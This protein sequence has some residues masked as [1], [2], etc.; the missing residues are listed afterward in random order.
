MVFGLELRSAGKAKQLRAA[1]DMARDRGDWV[2]A[3]DNYQEYLKIDSDDFAIWVQLGHALKEQAK[4]SQAES[5]YERA[6]DINPKDADIHLQ[7]GHLLKIVGRS[8]DAI[9]SYTRSYEIEPTYAAEAEIKALRG[10]SE[11]IFPVGNLRKY[12]SNDVVYIELDDMLI[13]LEAHSTV[14]GIQRVQAEFARYIVES[15][16]EVN[17]S[18]FV[19][20]VNPPYQDCVWRLNP[21]AVLDVVNYATGEKVDH[22]YLRRLVAAARSSA[23]RIEPSKGQCYL[24]LGAFWVFNTVSGRFLHLKRLGLRIGGYIHDLIPINQPEYCD[25]GLCHE[26]LLS[27]GDSMQVFDF[28]LTNSHHTANEVIRYRKKLG[29]TPMPVEAVQLAHANKIANSSRDLW[30]PKIKALKGKKFAMMVSTIE[31]RKN[32]KYLVD[33]WRQ[34]YNEGLEPPDL[35]FV[36]RF[37]WRVN[38][39]MNTLKQSRNFGG[40]LHIMHGLTDG[41]LNKLYK[42]CSFTVFPSYVE[43]WGLPVGEGLAH[44]KP[45]VSSMTSAMPEIGG[46]F[47]DYIDPWNLRD[48]IEVLRKMCFDDQ[49]RESRRLNIEKNFVVR[50]WRDFSSNLVETV[51]RHHKEKIGERVSQANFAPGVIFRPNE[52]SFGQQLPADYAVNPV[53]LLLSS[54]WGAVEHWGAWMLG[55]HGEIEFKSP[56]Q[57][58][59]EIVAYLDLFGAPF[60][61]DDGYLTATVGGANEDVPLDPKQKWTKIPADNSFVIKVEGAVRENGVVNINVYVN[62]EVRLENDL[63][64]A[65]RFSVGIKAIAYALK[66]DAILRTDITEDIIGGISRV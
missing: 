32:H 25:E 56:Y 21:E 54:S 8:D 3:S 57:E 6:R 58:G 64:G 29:L 16:G 9:E 65:R 20:V 59:D 49:Y 44:G 30:T 53:R 28:I 34:F 33:A 12:V 14:S 47:V 5:A 36:G 24:V 7:I 10:N 39:L 66:Q 41:E 31:A 55:S 13:Y 19:F 60:V 63:P 4:Y 2:V 11:D 18:Q 1:G 51:I 62:G 45:C 61:G 17:G 40:R 22:D 37:G 23:T 46:D 48:G 27:F 38:D 26:F 15:G 52:L 50:T 42:E 43:G 35:V